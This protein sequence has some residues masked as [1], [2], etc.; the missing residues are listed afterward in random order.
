LSVISSSPGELGPVFQKMLESATRVCGATFGTMTLHEG[1]ILRHVALYNTPAAFTE[2]WLKT[3]FRPHPESGLGCVVRTKQVAH[4]DDI[5]TQAA[6]LDG[7]PAAGAMADVAG[8]R[9]LVIVPMLREGGLIGTIGIFRQ[10]IR[11]FTDKQ[12]EL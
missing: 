9:S 2:T 8:A 4:F 6:Y 3:P 5:R 1:G 10:E 7:N 12:I 11:P